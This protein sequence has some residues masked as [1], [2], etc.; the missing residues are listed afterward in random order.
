[1]NDSA[2]DSVR[3]PFLR[4]HVCMLVF[5]VPAGDPEVRRAL[6]AMLDKTSTLL[7]EAEPWVIAYCKDVL[8]HYPAASQRPRVALEH[9]GDVW[10]HVRFGGEL[11]VSRRTHGD[12]EDGI[13]FSLECGCDWEREHGLQLVIRDGRTVTKV[14]SFDGHL[15]NADAY[16]D[17]SLVG[18]VYVP[19][20][21]SR[22]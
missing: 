17:R 11:T 5:E 7:A 3:V 8:A 19:L 1:M 20:D 16:G 13:Y 14:G 12:D 18:R 6:A 22:R 10:S 21:R 2:S 9:P 4:D 15:T